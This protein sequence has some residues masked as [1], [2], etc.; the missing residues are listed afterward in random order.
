MQEL[1][2]R[3]ADEETVARDALT[4]RAREQESSARSLASQAGEAE[5]LQGQV[6]RLQGQVESKV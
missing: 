2:R 3:L 6:M 4:L 5:R 1:Q